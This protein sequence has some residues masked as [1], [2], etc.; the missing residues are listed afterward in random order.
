MPREWDT[1]LR[2]PWNPVIHRLLKAID[3]HMSLYLET[4]DLWHV[5]KAQILRGYV[6]ELKDWISAQE[7]NI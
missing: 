1:P 4:G 6:V 5:H 2:E 7:G 3:T